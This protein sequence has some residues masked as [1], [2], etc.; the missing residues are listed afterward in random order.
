MVC[1]G[2]FLPRFH[3]V[4]SLVC[5]KLAFYGHVLVF[6]GA[7]ILVDQQLADALTTSYYTIEPSPVQMLYR[8]LAGSYTNEIYTLVFDP[9]TS[10][11]TSVAA[12]TVGVNPSWIAYHPGDHSLIFAVLEEHEGK[13]AAVKFDEN[14]K[15]LHSGQSSSGGADPCSILVT[16]DEVII[17]NVR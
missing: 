11:L 9:C 10:S 12:T 8:I 2:D 17:G 13:V 3:H 6:I 4:T 16:R 14:G 15:V 7:S 5:S 1:C